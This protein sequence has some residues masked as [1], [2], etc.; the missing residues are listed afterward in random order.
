MTAHRTEAGMSESTQW[1]I[2]T[3]VLMLLVL[4]II[5]GAVW[6]HGRTVAANAAIAAA[7]DAALLNASVASARAVGERVA[8]LGGLQRVTVQVTVSADQVQAVV[9]GSM[10]IF[11][12]VGQTGVREQATRPR[13]QVTRP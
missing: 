11:L 6:W 3:P 1:A 13:E 10:P 8:A 4:G 7:E 5:Q 12:D 2:L 9:T